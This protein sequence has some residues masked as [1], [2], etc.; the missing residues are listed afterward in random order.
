MWVA[1]NLRCFG[2][3]LAQARGEA[4][5]I[6]HGGNAADGLRSQIDL[7]LFTP[8]FAS[9]AARDRTIPARSEL[10]VQS[11]RR[12]SAGGC[13]GQAGWGPIVEGRKP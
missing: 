8:V 5:V 6:A 2:A 11:A 13:D 10:S 7:G 3:R 9:E 4:S 12:Y 1:M